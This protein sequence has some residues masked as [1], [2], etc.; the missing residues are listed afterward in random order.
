MVGNAQH[1]VISARIKIGIFS[2]IYFPLEWSI[3]IIDKREYVFHTKAYAK[4]G[5]RSP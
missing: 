1:K 4:A 2:K 3:Y 5:L